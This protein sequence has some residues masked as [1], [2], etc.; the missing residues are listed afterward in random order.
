MGVNTISKVAGVTLSGST[1]N[2]VVTVTG[3][4]SLTGES[5]LTFD[6]TDLAVGNAAP[7]SYIDSVHGVIVG[8]TGDA[9]SEIVL[10]SSTTGVS[11]LNFTD[12][13]D[14]TN[15]GQI[16]YDHTSNFMS[17]DTAAAEAMR[18][19]SDGDLTI[20]TTSSNGST[21][22]VTGDKAGF[23]SQ[24]HNTNSST[25]QGLYMN[26]SAASP[27]NNTQQFL[28]CVDSTTTR[29]R[30]YSDGDLQNH[31]NSY[32]A[33]SD[34]R[35]KQD[36]VDASSQWDDIKN[37]RVRKYKFIS[38]VEA[39]GADAVAQI[40]VIAQEAELVS[41]GLVQHRVSDAVLDDDGNEVQPAVDQYS[42]QYS[43]LYM[44]CVKALQEAMARIETLEAQVAALQGA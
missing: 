27:D 18:I 12:T 36:I 16:L 39:H 20:G 35:L 43:V 11:E 13:A 8:D 26:F 25:P 14:T 37:L 33:I 22:Y 42:V 9:T 34:E 7:S 15:Q 1:N 6:G 21:F 17:F 24:I 31:D 5:N 30:I 38:D 44:K 10:A 41:P 3:G 28:Q 32:G 40:G 4:N 29:C 23:V 2:E 19:T